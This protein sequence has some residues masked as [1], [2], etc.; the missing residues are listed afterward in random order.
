MCHLGMH[1]LCACAN[2]H[3]SHTLAR[4]LTAPS[5]CLAGRC[6][7]RFRPLFL[8]AALSRRLPARQQPVGADDVC[9]LERTT[10]RL[11]LLFRRV[12]DSLVRGRTHTALSTFICPALF[13]YAQ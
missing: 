8:S 1:G 10:L 13:P 4:P 2:T 3:P 7:L 5:A 9:F 11:A 6:R 12:L